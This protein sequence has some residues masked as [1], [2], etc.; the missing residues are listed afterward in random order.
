LPERTI[1][2]SVAGRPDHKP[3]PDM[4]RPLS[5]GREHCCCGIESPSRSC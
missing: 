4:V 1:E 3:L 5:A 2:L